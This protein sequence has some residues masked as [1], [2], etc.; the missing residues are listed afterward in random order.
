MYSTT[1]YDKGKGRIFFD[2][3]DQETSVLKVIFRSLLGLTSDA[4][5]VNPDSITSTQ[6]F[7]MF[8]D[9]GYTD[10]L[11]TVTK[12]KKLCLPPQWNGLFTLLFKGFV[13]RVVGSDGAS[14]SFMTILSCL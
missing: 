13:E 11:T 9:M 8:Y 6:L 7:T 14:K 5:L 1:S 12:F 3:F 2:I 4:S 10:I